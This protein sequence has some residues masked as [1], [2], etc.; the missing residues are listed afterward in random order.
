MGTKR[1]VQSIPNLLAMGGDLLQR[2]TKKKGGVI[3]VIQNTTELTI[4]TLSG[5]LSSG[6]PEK[7]APM[8]AV[9]SPLSQHEVGFFSPQGQWSFGVQ[10]DTTYKTRLTILHDA[11]HANLERLPPD[12]SWTADLQQNWKA[13]VPQIVITFMVRENKPSQPAETS[14]KS[15]SNSHKY[16]K[17]RFCHLAASPFFENPLF[18][19]S[20]GGN[21]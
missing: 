6:K 5:S 17:P 18:Q 7:S 21:Y 11:E 4:N 14:S 1:R 12:A 16:G 19:P 13:G 8:P 2:L 15:G 20:T 9:I 10:G 3:L